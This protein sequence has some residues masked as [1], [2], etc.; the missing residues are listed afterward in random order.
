[1]NHTAKR[2]LYR[3]AVRGAMYLATGLTALLTLFLVG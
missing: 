2:T 3:R 1:M